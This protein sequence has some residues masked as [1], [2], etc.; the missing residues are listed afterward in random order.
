MAIIA[1]PVDSVIVLD[2][3]VGT[4]AQGSPIMSHR[5]YPGVKTATSDADLYAVA[6]AMQALSAD[7]LIS[8]RRENRIDLVDDGQ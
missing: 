2:V 8:V 7:P 1:S 5:S 6:A 4:T 3:Q